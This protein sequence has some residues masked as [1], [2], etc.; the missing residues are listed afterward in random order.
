MTKFTTL[1]VGKSCIFDIEDYVSYLPYG[2][3]IRSDGKGYFSVILYKG[4]LR[5]KVF[6]RVLLTAPDN[7]IVDHIDGNPLNNCKSNLRLASA[8]QSMANR[9][10]VNQLQYKGISRN[11]NGY[12]ASIM[13]DRKKIYLGTFP[14]Q[15]LAGEA[16]AKAANKYFEDFA[17]VTQG[18]NK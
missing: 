17:Y 10:S 11:G 4:K 13:V 15:E 1:L 18:V 9:A 6:S 2:F 5:G 14:T 7:L 16:Y 3:S 8:S 12:A